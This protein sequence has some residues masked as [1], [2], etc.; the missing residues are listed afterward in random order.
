[1]L[2]S[3]RKESGWKWNYVGGA[4]AVMSADVFNLSSRQS[5]A[6][7][8]ALLY[9]MR[10]R[11]CFYSLPNSLTLLT[12]KT[13][14]QEKKKGQLTMRIG[15]WRWSAVAGADESFNSSMAPSRKNREN[16]KPFS[17]SE[18]GTGEHLR[19]LCWSGTEGGLSQREE[20]RQGLQPMGSQPRAV[21][22][23]KTIQ[24]SRLSAIALRSG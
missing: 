22:A 13:I 3:K 4:V 18:V 10:N 12:V 6:G 23:F 9:R 21:A 8:Q 16:L 20:F 2:T 1:M 24:L 19:S 11:D 15:P 17:L 14:F 7:N 5:C